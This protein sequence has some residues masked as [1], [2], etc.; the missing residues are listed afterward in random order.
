MKIELTLTDEERS[1]LLGALPR[2]AYEQCEFASAP[3]STR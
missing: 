2:Q 1:L 3:G